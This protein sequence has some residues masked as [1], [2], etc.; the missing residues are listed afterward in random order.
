[1][2]KGSSYS[3]HSS[4]MHLPSEGCTLKGE[5]LGTSH[6]DLSVTEA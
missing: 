6:Y 4:I 3:F 2:T 1:L 5:D